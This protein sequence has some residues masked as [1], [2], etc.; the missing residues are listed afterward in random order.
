MLNY[1]PLSQYVCSSCGQIMKQASFDID[2][3]TIADDCPK[4]GARLA[5]TLKRQASS[6]RAHP[7]QPKFQ[8]A[9]DLTRFTLDIPKIGKLVS[10]ESAGSLCIVGDSA[11]LLLTRLCVRALLPAS[12][13]GLDSPNVVVVDAGN[14]SDFYQTVNFVRQYGLDVQS[15]L[16]RIIV[17]RPFTIYQLK[18]LLQQLPKV[19]QKYQARVV[20]VPGLLD[21][22][23]DPNIKK[24]EAKQVIQRTM[25]SI[26]DISSKLLVVASVQQSGYANM[27]L[28]D[29]KQQVIW[30]K[31]EHGKLSVSVYNNAK[32]ASLTITDKEL[33]LITK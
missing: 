9:Y 13:G 29:F 22:F 12:Y 21:L 23:D 24:K 31:A 18:S 8:T 32:S 2:I 6:T 3:A 33:K 25:H 19:V 5:E 4:C 1:G 10:L 28:P 27:I 17:S 16:D 14:K 20:I 11:N 15:A 30:H 7:D 26:S